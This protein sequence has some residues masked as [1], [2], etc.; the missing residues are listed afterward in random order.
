M[1]W[2]WMKSKSEHGTKEKIDQW[3]QAEKVEDQRIKAQFNGQINHFEQGVRF[4]HAQKWA[5]RVQQRLSDDVENFANTR[6]KQPSF[7]VG[8]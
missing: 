7:E 1:S 4:R 5:H 8:W 3:F 6:L 2:N